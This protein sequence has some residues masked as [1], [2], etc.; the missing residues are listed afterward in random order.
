MC[1]LKAGADNQCFLSGH[2]SRCDITP[3][4]PFCQAG[5]LGGGGRNCCHEREFVVPSLIDPG[6]PAL[7]KALARLARSWLQEI[8]SI[9]LVKSWIDSTKAYH[10][11][12]PLMSGISKAV[13]VAV[14][15][16]VIGA[17][18][19]DARA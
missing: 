6:T 16:A 5:Q 18:V 15:V 3:F 11:S 17:A 10:V 9:H 1:D 14:V 4:H 12:C 7:T 19:A 13:V 2:C 8:I